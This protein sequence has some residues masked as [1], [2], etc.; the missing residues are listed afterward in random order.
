ML[1]R[2]LAWRARAS[3]LSRDAVAEQALEQ[4]ARIEN[5]R[6][7]LRLASPRQIVGVGAGV[8]GIAIAGLARVFHAE[9]ERREPRLIA[10]LIG[11]NLV[12][13]N[14]G[15]DIDQSSS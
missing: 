12:A 5:R 7:R 3:G 6:Q 15:L 4:R 10:D 14:A 1:R 9:F 8:A 11:D 13:G 2:Y